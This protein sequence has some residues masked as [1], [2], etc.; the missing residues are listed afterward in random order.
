MAQPV[1]AALEEAQ[2]VPDL[3]ASIQRGMQT[4]SLAH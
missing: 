2:L 1:S 4:P 3:R